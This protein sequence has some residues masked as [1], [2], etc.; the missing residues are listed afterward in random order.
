MTD[1]FYT[2]K[3]LAHELDV[4]ES[5]VRYWRDRY[6][7]FI[8]SV[9]QGKRRKYR[10]E[11]LE[12]LRFI[13]QEAN[14]SKTAAEIKEGL[15]QIFPVNIEHKQESQRSSAAAQQQHN[16]EQNLPSVQEF[17]G[18]VFERVRD[19]LQEQNQRMESLEAEN[20][21][22][23]DRLARLEEQ[24][25]I[26]GPQQQALNLSRQ[27]VVGYIKRLRED[28]MSFRGWHEF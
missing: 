6:H 22:L 18:E 20:R 12:V 2:I 9:G 3:E 27:Q 25:K 10:S 16:S 28:G 13:Q 5:T 19:I 15:T 17:V 24:T 26:P 11:A 7:E 1:K 8:P 14:R 23:R 21:E 4:G